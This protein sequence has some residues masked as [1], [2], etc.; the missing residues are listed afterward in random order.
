MSHERYLRFTIVS[1]VFKERN[2]VIAPC[3]KVYSR[4][5]QHLFVLH[6]QDDRCAT[7][8]AAHSVLHIKQSGVL[9][10]ER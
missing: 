1:K 8:L 3:S 5:R 6:D 9:E 7:T 4:A 2:V 10:S